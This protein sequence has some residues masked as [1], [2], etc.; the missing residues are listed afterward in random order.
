MKF[1]V[2]GQPSLAI[3]HVIPMLCI[4]FV[5][6]AEGLLVYDGRIVISSA[7]KSEILEVIH[8]SH[9]GITKSNERGKEGV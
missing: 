1:T 7:L 9:S 8:H 5:S 6:V 3:S 4:L 2:D